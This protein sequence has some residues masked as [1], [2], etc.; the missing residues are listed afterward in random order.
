MAIADWRWVVLKRVNRPVLDVREI[1]A[2]QAAKSPPSLRLCQSV[3][4]RG[5]N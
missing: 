2:I 4:C 1:Y 3:I 5:Q